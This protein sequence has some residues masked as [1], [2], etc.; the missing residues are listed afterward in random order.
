[1]THLPTYT[2]AKLRQQQLDKITKPFRARGHK[3]KRCQ[4][5]L[6]AASHC[7]CDQIKISPCTIDIMILMHPKELLKPTNSGRLIADILPHSSHIFLWSRTE[8]EPALLNFIKDKSRQCLLVFP[9]DSD[10]EIYRSINVDTRLNKQPSSNKKLTLIMLDGTWKQARKMYNKSCWLEHI[11]CLS[12]EPPLAPN[13]MQKPNNYGLRQAS[14]PHLS[15][16]CEAAAAALD[17]LGEIE[18]S[19]ALNQ[20]FQVFNRYYLASRAN[21]LVACR[22]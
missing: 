8:P 19:Q 16:T 1:M 20:Y 18:A 10:R 21:T 11:P 15:S 4:Q 17:S 5:C 2:F 6:L 3:L 7:I 22:T 14:A 12:I 13:P 9:A